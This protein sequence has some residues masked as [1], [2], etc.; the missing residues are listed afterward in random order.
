MGHLPPEELLEEDRVPHARRQCTATQARLCMEG[1]PVAMWGKC[2]CYAS[3][4][5]DDVLH[6]RSLCEAACPW[7]RH[8][9]MRMPHKKRRLASPDVRVW[10]ATDKGGCGRR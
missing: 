3:V 2:E 4:P 7:H 1:A 5:F 10:H 8:R 6:A 9:Q